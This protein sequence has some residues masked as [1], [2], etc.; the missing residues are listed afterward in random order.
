MMMERYLEAV[1]F[2]LPVG[3]QEDI[4][5]ELRED[6]RAEVSDREMELGRKLT[7]ADLEE[8]L[9]RRGSPLM[10]AQPY[11]PQRSLIGPLLFPLYWLLLKILT[12][13]VFGLM[14]LGWIGMA[15]ARGLSGNVDLATLFAGV[16]L[17]SMIHAWLTAA[18]V[19]TLIFTLV[20]NSDLKRR[21][22]ETWNPRK[23][24][25]VRRHH[26]LSRSSAIAEAAIL[27]CVAALWTATM[28]SPLR[29][30]TVAILLDNAWQT[31]YWIILLLVLATVA[32]AAVNA[33]R[34]WNSLPRQ[35]IRALLEAAGAATFCWFLQAG[36]VRGITWPGATATTSAALVAG[37]QHILRDAFPVAVMIGL[38]MLGWNLYRIL[39]LRQALRAD[40]TLPEMQPLS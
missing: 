30:G 29:F 10:V 16:D 35:T 19:L 27:L 17:G 33:F 13:W 37:V 20:E 12:L 1:R 36:I 28:H 3:Q 4:V 31:F 39:R 6:L 32:L 9:R 34:P 18:A 8:L 11:L 23:L 25:P 26:S 24:P 15:L 2:W 21:I 38:G 14:A 22:L 40:A 5:A 7:E